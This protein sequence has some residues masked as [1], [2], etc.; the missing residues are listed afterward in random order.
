MNRDSSSETVALAVHKHIVDN[1]RQKPLSDEQIISSTIRSEYDIITFE[2]IDYMKFVPI[3][4][5]FMP[6][7]KVI[8]PLELDIQ[9]RKNLSE[10]DSHDL[11][12]YIKAS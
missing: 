5:Q 7:V 4:Q 3:I 2:T 10:Y 8:M 1:F 12:T 11:S 6:F 9:I